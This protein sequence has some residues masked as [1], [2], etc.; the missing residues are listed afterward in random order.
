MME[1]G[2]GF[3]GSLLIAGLAYR[4]R[5]LSR[6]GFAAAVLLG[7]LLYA[8]GTAAWFGTLIAFFVTSS[9]LSHWKKQRKAAAES[10]YAKSGRR[11]AGQVLANGGLAL[12]LCALY[13]LAPAPAWWH[14]FIGVMA[15]VTADTWATEIGGLSRT[16]PRHILTGRPVAPG[17]SGGVTPLGWGAAAAGGAFIGAAAWLLQR[18]PADATGAAGAMADPLPGLAVLG[19]ACGLA[20]ALADSLLGASVQRLYRCRHCRREVERREHCGAGTE[21]IRGWR[22]MTND[23]VNLL[24]SAAGGLAAVGLGMLLL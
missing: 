19:A 5:S 2:A 23:A 13:S 12:A 1:L 11:D 20:G 24:S 10:G 8:W 16:R 6:S 21:P 7:T 18:I 17:T 9:L 3:A 4:K 22:W 15:T 14:A